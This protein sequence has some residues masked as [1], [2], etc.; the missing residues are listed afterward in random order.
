[1][2][3]AGEGREVGERAYARIVVGAAGGWRMLL[4]FV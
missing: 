2:V 1:M 3:M 4:W